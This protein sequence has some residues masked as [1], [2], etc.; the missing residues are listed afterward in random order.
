MS[1]ELGSGRTVPADFTDEAF[2]RSLRE[3]LTSTGAGG[4]RSVWERLSDAQSNARAVVE[5]LATARTRDR[6]GSAR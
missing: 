2:A 4:P 6:R 5:L 1:A 3:V